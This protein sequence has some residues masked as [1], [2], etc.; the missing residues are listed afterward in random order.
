M[1]ADDKQ[2]ILDTKVLSLGKNELIEFALSL[3]IDKSKVE[4]KSKVQII[5]EIRNALEV[6]L[7]TF[8]EEDDKVN[9]L[10]GLIS[11]LNPETS[12]TGAKI[13]EE[14]TV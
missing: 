13:S 11:A 14:Q 6:N 12:E 3:K 5:K 1:A 7:S 2:I 4:G 9:Y 10:D 8:T